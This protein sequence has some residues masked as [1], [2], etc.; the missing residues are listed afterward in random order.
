MIAVVALLIGFTVVA[1]RLGSPDLRFTV[2][3]IALLAFTVIVGHYVMAA[4]RSREKTS[5]AKVV[6]SPASAGDGLVAERDTVPARRQ[7]PAPMQPPTIG[8]APPVPRLFIGRDQCLRELKLRLGLVGGQM[9]L[10]AMQPVTIIRG[11]PG[12]GKT[13]SAA[14]LAHDEEVKQA[15]PDGIVWTSLGQGPEVLSELALWGRV[16]GSE[17]LLHAA[18]Q[19]DAIAQIRDLLK[20]KHALLIVDDVWEALDGEPFLRA[21]GIQSSLLRECRSRPAA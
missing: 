15:F 21:R 18:T 17:D 12:V 10:A 11:T 5:E 16:F 8:A 19:D 3:V 2:V 6:A 9:R 14:A 13:T 1:S 7:E 20:N 4:L